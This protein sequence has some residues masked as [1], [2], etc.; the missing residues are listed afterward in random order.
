M[1]VHKKFFNYRPKVLE[2]ISESMSPR[3]FIETDSVRKYLQARAV[4]VTSDSEITVVYDKENYTDGKKIHV[5]PIEAA[6]YAETQEEA[7]MMLAGFV[8]HEALHII[9]TDFD[10]YEEY[11][12][13]HFDGKILPEPLPKYSSYRINIL[14]IVED[15]AI[16]EWGKKEFPAFLKQSINFAN[17]VSFS[18]RK[19]LKEMYDE[20]VHPIDI[21]YESFTEYIIMGVDPEF[22]RELEGYETLY[23]ECRPLLSRAK[24]MDSA[25]E[26]CRIAEDIFQRIKPVVVKELGKS[27]HFSVY[28]PAKPSKHE[29]FDP[30]KQLEMQAAKKSA[31]ADSADDMAGASARKELTK[32]ELLEMLVPVGD[33][34]E[35]FTLEEL[36]GAAARDIYDKEIDEEYS[37]Q[38]VLDI[39]RMNVSSLGAMHNTIKVKFTA[40]EP[41][42]YDQF[43]AEHRR[44][45]SRLR[46]KIKILQKSIL[47]VIQREHDTTVR[48]LYAGNQYREP[49]RADKKCCS[50]RKDLSDEADLFIFVLVDASG[51]MTAEIET[52]KDALTMFSEVCRSLNLPITVMTHMASANKVTIKTLIDGNMRKNTFAG[53]ET[54]T[55]GGGTR[56]G[57]ALMNVAEYLRTRRETQKILIAI[58][59]GQPWHTCQLE[60]ND[61]LYAIAAS[62]GVSASDAKEFFSE[63]S[64][65]SNSDIRNVIRKTGIRPVG[66]ALAPSMED[67]QKLNENIRGLYPESFATDLNHLAKKL[68]DLIGKRMFD[69]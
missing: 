41:S 23:Y 66:V 46:P 38:L 8:F 54:F 69:I 61:E 21:L 30:K 3:N 56:D 43:Y 16:E 51:S 10:I 48:N 9:R 58:S 22:P 17:E 35:G 52:I 40:A 44:R 6:R 15:G 14:S 62:A 64:N 1:G 20:R 68:S 24:H 19:S 28:I 32:D 49:F 36:L 25:K 63:Y 34:E 12:M 26:R 50:I 47:S 53:I 4:R 42:E 65:F 13:G 60:M 45:I 27:D 59:D 67:A 37:N 31:E 18:H 33:D 55:T 29:S 57:V 2:T 11:K 5:S 7:L 39:D